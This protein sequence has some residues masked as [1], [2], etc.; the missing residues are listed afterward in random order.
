MGIYFIIAT[1]SPAPHPQPLLLFPGATITTH[2]PFAFNI[3]VF[4]SINHFALQYF[5][6]FSILWFSLVRK[7]Q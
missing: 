1:S 6:F 2:L 3:I 5:Y 4:K 7:Y